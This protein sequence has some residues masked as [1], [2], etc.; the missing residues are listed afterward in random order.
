MSA[1]Y[2]SGTRP[3]DSQRLSCYCRS[4]Q[5][6]GLRRPSRP[7]TASVGLSR[8]KTASAPNLG[9]ALKTCNTVKTWVRHSCICYADGLVTGSRSDRGSTYVRLHVGVG[10]KCLWQ[11]RDVIGEKGVT[12]QGQGVLLPVTLTSPVG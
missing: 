3:L 6:V 8:P 1:V 10:M 4:Q 5:S 7:K 9:R 2:K 12:K 11:P